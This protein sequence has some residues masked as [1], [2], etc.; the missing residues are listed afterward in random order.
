[1]AQTLADKMLEK[2]ETILLENVGLESVNVDG[3]SVAYADLEKKYDYWRKR[4]QREQGQAPV[5][6]RIRLDQF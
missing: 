6:S 5:I 4:Q 3:S 2:L 1:M